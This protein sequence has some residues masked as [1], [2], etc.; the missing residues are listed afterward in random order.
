MG[1]AACCFDALAAMTKSPAFA[2]LFFGHLFPR[3]ASSPSTKVQ[4]GFF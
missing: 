4:P 1:M 2:G 3:F